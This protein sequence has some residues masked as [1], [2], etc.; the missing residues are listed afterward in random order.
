MCTMK[1]K[2]KEKTCSRF[3]RER[4]DRREEVGVKAGEGRGKG[5]M[6]EGGD[7]LLLTG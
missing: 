3:P 1:K 6:A 4:V 7:C 5:S 2:E